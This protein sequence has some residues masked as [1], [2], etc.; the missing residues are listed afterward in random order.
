MD[1]L[2]ISIFYET[3]N[4]HKEF[5]HFYITF[6]YFVFNKSL[7]SFI[8]HFAFFIFFRI[9]YLSKCSKIIR[10]IV[11]LLYQ[12]IVI[13]SRYFLLYKYLLLCPTTFFKKTIMNIL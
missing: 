3:Y 1:Y 5:I 9:K 12:K 8:P 7:S 4:F 11:P 6:I 2:I 10:T 13:K